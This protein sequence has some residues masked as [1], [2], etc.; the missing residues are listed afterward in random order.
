VPALAAALSVTVP[1]PLRDPGVVDEIVGMAF[2]V[3]VTIA[4][5]SDVQARLFNV[6]TVVRLYWVVAVKPDG[7]S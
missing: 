6:E 2:T 7:G 5:G 4:V 3:T 1:V